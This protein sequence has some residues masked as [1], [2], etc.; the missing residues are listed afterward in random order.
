MRVSFYFSD[1][2]KEEKTEQARALEVRSKKEF[3]EESKKTT[4]EDLTRGIVNYKYL[5]LDFV[6]GE[7]Q[8]LRYDNTFVGFDSVFLQ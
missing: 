5:G 6:K 4:I 2:E 1:L 8:S 3:A 7:N